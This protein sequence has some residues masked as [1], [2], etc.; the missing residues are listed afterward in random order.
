[1]YLRAMSSEGMHEKLRRERLSESVPQVGRERVVVVLYVAI[2]TCVFC[3]EFGEGDLRIFFEEFVALCA[4]VSSVF[5]T[6][7]G[8]DRLYL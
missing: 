3:G 4:Q 6:R 8:G 1:V 5:L 7:L 2:F